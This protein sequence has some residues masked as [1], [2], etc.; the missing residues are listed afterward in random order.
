M[1]YLL[2]LLIVVVK[3]HPVVWMDRSYLEAMI[4]CCRILMNGEEEIYVEG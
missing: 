3:I 4:L 1:C 2:L